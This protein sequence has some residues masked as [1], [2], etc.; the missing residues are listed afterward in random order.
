MNIVDNK[1]YEDGNAPEDPRQEA[2]SDLYG[3]TQTVFP[4]RS[5]DV[6]R[7][8]AGR[9]RALKQI[10]AGSMGI[11][12]L[13]YDE[14]S[15]VEVALKTVGPKYADDPE[16]M[17]QV[18]VNFRIV[19]QLNHPNIGNAKSL[20]L[21]SE[22]GDHFLIM[23]FVD[24]VSLATLLKKKKHG[25][26]DLDEI[27]PIMSRMAN[28]LDYSHEKS[29]VHRDV[30]PSNIMLDR[31]GTPKLLDFGIAGT[32]ISTIISLKTGL[33]GDDTTNKSGTP[34]YMAPEQWQGYKQNGRTDQYGLAATIYHLLSGTPPYGELSDL[35]TVRTCAVEVPIE[36]LN[37]L[38]P[39]V[40]DVLEKA[41]NKDKDFRYETCAA[42]VKALDLAH[43]SKSTSGKKI[44]PMKIAFAAGLALIAGAFAVSS[45]NKVEPTQ[46]QGIIPV[47][48]NTPIP[49]TLRYHALV[50]G[51]NEY[52]N[53]WQPLKNAA[54][55]AEAVGQVLNDQY[56]FS[57]QYLLNEQ[58]TKEN[59]LFELE[60][61][62]N[63]TVEDMVLIYFAGHGEH[64][65]KLAEGYW[66]PYDGRSRDKASA[67]KSSWLWN[68]IITK[69]L[70]AS[71]ARH[72]LV[73]AD[74]CYAGS[75]IN[76]G[77]PNPRL[78]DK[79]DYQQ[80]LN[81]PSRYVIASGNAWETVLDA[82]TRHSPFAEHFLHYLENAKNALFS[83]SDIALA[84]KDSY[85]KDTQKSMRVAPLVKDTRGEFVFA[86]QNVKRQ[87]SL[88]D[89]E[90][91]WI[92]ER[93]VSSEPHKT[94]GLLSRG[95]H[96]GAVQRVKQKL[97]RTGSSDELVDQ[98]SVI[99]RASDRT[100]R[101]Q[102]VNALM[103]T[104]QSLKSQPQEQL[105]EKLRF[106]ARPRLV[107]IIGPSTS[108][109][110]REDQEAALTYSLMLKAALQLH[111]TRVVERDLL[112][113]ILREQEIS[114]SDLS[115]AR[116]QSMIGK[117]MPASLI[118]TGN[119]IAEED[120]EVLAMALVDTATSIELQSWTVNLE[121]NENP[122]A[123][124]AGL[125]KDIQ[126]IAVSKHPFK[127]RLFHVDQAWQALAGAFHGV[128]QATR[129]DIVEITKQQHAFLDDEQKKS[130]GTATILEVRETG[131]VLDVAWANGKAPAGLDKVWVIE[132]APGVK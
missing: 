131:S 95:G 69:Y 120:G 106:S 53:G 64:Y 90:D 29:I 35:E 7:S 58:A 49:Q 122:H 84:M 24:G 54:G 115:D 31:D 92:P 38:P 98:I 100:A 70:E 121:A 40:W 87:G 105:S 94:L 57:V 85:E 103:D 89:I 77:L 68:T 118:L 43:T 126:Q 59:I 111:G 119:L 19:Q 60:H 48:V 36:P 83:A 132:N 73:V 6:P 80:L 51:I 112:V 62:T 8:F 129:F 78:R 37:D 9:Y 11:V 91:G 1:A 63:K 97:H 13:C 76:S 27:I 110:R 47:V 116:V 15:G 14:L 96:T 124:M 67:A 56:G 66:I 101:I 93:L 3:E 33:H 123:K 21:D 42:F 50:I 23:E 81:R 99:E 12:W 114:G 25:K 16:I 44:T 102:Q 71:S 107:T 109:D 82:G 45:M 46:N 88:M 108:S 32:F 52:A 22:T 79:T 4:R 5:P 113:E 117:L 39:A 75:L 127:A 10:G 34:Y 104:L 28:A 2:E 74:A 65:T 128:D 20:D 61:I 125:A 72:I 26:M 86:Q 18:K 17:E 55:D 30:K 41:L 130:L